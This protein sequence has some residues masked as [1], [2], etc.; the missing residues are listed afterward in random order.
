M[1]KLI[2]KLNTRLKCCPYIG[3]WALD[4]NINFDQMNTT[5]SL[6]PDLRMC[7]LGVE[8]TG[9]GIEMWGHLFL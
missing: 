3:S 2:H 1:L 5:L 8:N 4:L 7:S 9:G 6:G